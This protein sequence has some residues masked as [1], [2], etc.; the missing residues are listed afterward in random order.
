MFTITFKI[1][2]SLGAIQCSREY[3]KFRKSISLHF[4]CSFMQLTTTTWVTRTFLFLECILSWCYHSACRHLCTVL[5]YC[6]ASNRKLSEAWYE[7]I[8]QQRETFEGENFRKIFSRR[9]L[10]GIGCLCHAKGCRAPKFRGENFREQPQKL[11]IRGS[12]LL[13]K[14]PAIWYNV[15][16]SD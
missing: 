10:S 13:R 1:Y 4:N 7:A 15:L 16:L 3:K 5:F 14:F 11:E 8:I 6:I 9:K 2:W 12:F